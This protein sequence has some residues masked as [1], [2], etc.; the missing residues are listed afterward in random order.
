[1]RP[2]VRAST[3]PACLHPCMRAQVEY[4]ERALNESAVLRNILGEQVRM[5][6]VPCAFRAR[7]L[8]SCH[9]RAVRVTCARGVSVA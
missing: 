4:V 7:V 6:R 8:C 5:L 9:V 2:P 3:H 1:M